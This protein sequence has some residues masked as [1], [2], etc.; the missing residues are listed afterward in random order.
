MS[1]ENKKPADR[2]SPL[3]PVASITF[4]QGSGSITVDLPGKVGASGLTATPADK[5]GKGQYWRIWYDPRLHHHRVEYFEPA[6]EGERKPRVRYVPA[7]WC[8][9][10]PL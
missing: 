5:V 9:W 2:P 6:G 4:R 7:E 3:I 10:E 1:E 8:S